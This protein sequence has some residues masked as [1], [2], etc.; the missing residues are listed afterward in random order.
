MFHSPQL[1]TL[2]YN[3]WSVVAD[4]QAQKAFKK[5]HADPADGFKSPASMPNMRQGGSLYS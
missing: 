1:N 4:N 5:K 2:N 3:V